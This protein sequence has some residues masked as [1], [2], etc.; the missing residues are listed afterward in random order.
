MA[1]ANAVRFDG[2]SMWEELLDSRTL[3][4]PLASFPRLRHGSAEQ[5]EQV[6]ISSRGLYWE[7]LDED[8]SIDGLLAGRGG[9]TG[10]CRAAGAD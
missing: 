9:Q 10:S 2:D 5:R 4:V 6:S 3:G 8:I 1:R 7:A